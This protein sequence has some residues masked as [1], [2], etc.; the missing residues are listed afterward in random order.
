MKNSTAERI[1]RYVVATLAQIARALHQHRTLAA[2]AQECGQGQ[3]GHAS[4]HDQCAYSS[5][6]VTPR[7]FGYRGHR[8]TL[9]S[10]PNFDKVSAR[11]RLRPH[12]E[13]RRRG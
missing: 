9:P 3:S 11:L 7:L 2:L 10:K 8:L 1:K 5:L 12:A 13:K 4:P 6:A